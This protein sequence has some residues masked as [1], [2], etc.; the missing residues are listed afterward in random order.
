VVG[1]NLDPRYAIAR[2]L[3]WSRLN[4][5][6]YKKTILLTPVGATESRIPLAESLK[7][8]RL[9]PSVWRTFLL[10]LHAGNRFT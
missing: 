3:E 10:R 4:Q 9:T 2:L 7:V 5:T 8:T 1:F 6:L